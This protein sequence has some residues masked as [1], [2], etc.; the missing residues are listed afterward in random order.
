MAR[1]LSG[2]SDPAAPGE[3]GIEEAHRRKA[4]GAQYHLILLRTEHVYA[5]IDRAPRLLRLR[6]IHA[7]RDCVG[8]VARQPKPALPLR[9]RK[10]A[11]RCYERSTRSEPAVDFPHGTL[12]FRNIE[13][14]QRQQAG[15][16]VERSRRRI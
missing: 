6:G 9:L 4:A 3:G 14:M 1:K 16:A 13:K 12:S 8:G 2:V 7:R 10:A 11:M 5:G 15:G